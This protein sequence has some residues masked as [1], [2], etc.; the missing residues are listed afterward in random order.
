[1][2]RRQFKDQV[3][4]VMDGLD[5]AG[6]H[7]DEA[8]ALQTIIAGNYIVDDN[9]DINTIPLPETLSCSAARP[10]RTPPATGERLRRM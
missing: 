3:R 5:P 9:T 4:R 8:E 7:F 1:M 2:V 10:S 6:V